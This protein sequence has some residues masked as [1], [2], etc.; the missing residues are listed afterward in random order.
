MFAS[1]PIIVMLTT[2][3]SELREKDGYFC[4]CRVSRKSLC[5]TGGMVLHTAAST[6]VPYVKYCRSLSELEVGKSHIQ[7]I[8][9]DV[10]DL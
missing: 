4:Q 9:C 1:L 6:E 10:P 3:A 5:P 7:K 8:I 2:K